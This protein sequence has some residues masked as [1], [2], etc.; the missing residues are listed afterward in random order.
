MSSRVLTTEQEQALRAVTDAAASLE[1]AKRDR[2]A[3]VIHASGLG[4][5]RRV[6]GEA[7][8]IS[9]ARVHQIINGQ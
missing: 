3:A 4:L 7:A 2:D 5:G 8:G 6:V 9:H 1:A